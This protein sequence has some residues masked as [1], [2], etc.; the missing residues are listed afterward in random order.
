[1]T[2]SLIGPLSYPAI[3]TTLQQLGS[4]DRVVV[5]V[6]LVLVADVVNGAGESRYSALRV[7]GAAG[8]YQVTAG[9]T[10]LIVKTRYYATA[11]NAGWL[12][13]SGTADAGD[14]QLAAPAGVKS[15]N[16][17]A[18]GV[19]GGLNVLTANNPVEFDLYLNVAASR[20]PAVR[21]MTQNVSLY[22]FCV[23]VEV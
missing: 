21:C 16:S 22:V 20:Y 4:I 6:P 15:E 17:R 5:S 13:L 3:N 23:G 12:V 18:D 2:E 7:P 1:M 11:N 9:K 10:L 14:S 19:P 8:G